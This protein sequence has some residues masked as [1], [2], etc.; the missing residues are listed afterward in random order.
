MAGIKWRPF[1]RRYFR[2]HFHKLNFLYFDYNF[3]EFCSYVPSWQ[4]SI[5]VLD[6]GLALNRRQAISWTYAD[7]NRWHI[8]AVLGGKY[9]FNPR[10]SIFWWR[11]NI[12]YCFDVFITFSLAITM[13]SQWVRPRLK[14]PA[15]PL[16]A[17]L[18]AQVLIMEN[19]KAS[20]H[21]PYC[22]EFTGDRWISRTNGQ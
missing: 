16:F 5:F 15:S 8:F 2:R 22:G 1:S 20:P 21:L 4:Q 17:K 6:N 10:S 19:I 18:F 12:A 11:W 7:L 14:S 13:T 3:T 9:V